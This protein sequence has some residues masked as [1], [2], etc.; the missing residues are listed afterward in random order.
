MV[1][2]GAPRVDNGFDWVSR[3]LGR[4]I[5]SAIAAWITVA[6]AGFIALSE[7]DR[8][9]GHAV[10][11]GDNATIG[12]I[13]GPSAFGARDAWQVWQT[14]LGGSGQSGQPNAEL[15][16]N[17]I[18]GHTAFDLVFV[19]AYGVLVWR[20]IDAAMTRVEKAPDAEPG[21]SR[22]YA[23]YAAKWSLT[24]LIVAE[25]IEAVLL[26]WS[27]TRITDAAEALSSAI[28]L[29]ATAKWFAVLALIL[30][31][32]R[33]ERFR[34]R[35]RSWVGTV[36]H[37]LWVQRL[38]VVVLVVLVVATLVPL[39]G[40]LDQF[41]DALRRWI[42]SGW[43]GAWH[44]VAAIGAYALTAVGLILIGRMRADRG[45]QLATRSAP[46]DGGT[47]DRAGLYQPA[48]LWWWVPAPAAVAV[49]ALV[50]FALSPQ[51][52]DLF[53][54]LLVTSVGLTVAVG[55]LAVRRVET[56]NISDIS[57]TGVVLGVLCAL[58][59]VIAAVTIVKNVFAWPAVVSVA[60][61]PLV[62]AVIAAAMASYLKRRDDLV[63]HRSAKETKRACCGC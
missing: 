54:A 5:S 37:A 41:P 55:S 17:L 38:S 11:R 63:L 12:E 32:F 56:P 36:A 39:P 61:A 15:L 51:R 28:A 14:S 49:G 8:L 44:L 7:I 23:G 24:S 35:V 27:A 19:A 34:L 48:V 62:A 18:I 31:M 26:V 60:A 33:V 21:E 13:V 53:G 2:H 59:W 43:E 9:I 25:V 4:L 16:R 52:V 40:P 10:A 1:G 6:V 20:L 50:L 58:L 42:S 22:R 45:F 47:P 57:A 46:D 30:S 29:F 3:R